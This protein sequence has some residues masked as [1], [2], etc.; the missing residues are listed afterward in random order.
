MSDYDLF[1]KKRYRGTAILPVNF[2]DSKRRYHATD[3]MLGLPFVEFSSEDIQEIDKGIIW[4]KSEKDFAIK[5]E[6]AST[7]RAISR[8][9]EYKLR[10]EKIDNV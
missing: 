5:D 3:Y 6:L 10:Q 4:D 8:L 9:I 1:I 7:N 2:K